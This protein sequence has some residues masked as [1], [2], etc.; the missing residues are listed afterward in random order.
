MFVWSATSLSLEV[1]KPQYAQSL[2]ASLETSL[3]GRCAM[4]KGSET[5]DQGEGRNVKSEPEYLVLAPRH[6]AM[7]LADLPSWSCRALGR[8]NKMDRQGSASV[9]TQARAVSGLPPMD[10]GARPT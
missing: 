9:Y 1:T 2:L 4:Q 5:R 3:L 7:T 8:I 6:L 10:Q